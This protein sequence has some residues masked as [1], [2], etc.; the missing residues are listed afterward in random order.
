M[1]T[2]CPGTRPPINRDQRRKNYRFSVAW[3]YSPKPAEVVCVRRFEEFVPACRPRKAKVE[4]EGAGLRLLLCLH[5][6]AEQ[7]VDAGLIA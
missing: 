2:V 6:G 5:I 3:L 4:A 1:D 7:S